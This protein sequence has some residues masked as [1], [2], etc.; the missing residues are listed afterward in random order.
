MGG[1]SAVLG[2]VGVA[3][4]SGLAVTVFMA[5]MLLVQRRA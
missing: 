2:V 4:A 3:I 5:V 1:L